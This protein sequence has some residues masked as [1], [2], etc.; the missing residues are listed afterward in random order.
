MEFYPEISESLIN[1]F[2][3]V[4]CWAGT[5]ISAR[6]VNDLTRSG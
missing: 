6:N 2:H 3:R 1:S 5:E 4:H